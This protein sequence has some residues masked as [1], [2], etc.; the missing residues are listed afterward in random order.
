V[1][2]I[3]PAAELDDLTTPNVDAVVEAVTS[4]NVEAAA[5]AARARRRHTR[6]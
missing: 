6:G 1:Q 2:L 3:H 4:A 5:P